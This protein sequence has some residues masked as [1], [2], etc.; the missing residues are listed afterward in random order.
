MTM[1]LATSTSGGYVREVDQNIATA[2]T[3]I[4]YDGLYRFPTPRGWSIL[5]ESTLRI[6]NSNL[7]DDVKIRAKSF[8]NSVNPILSLLAQRMNSFPQ[9]HSNLLEDGSVIFEL[10]RPGIRLTFNIES[11]DDESSWNLTTNDKKGSVWS[12][13]RLFP[14][15][16]MNISW[17]VTYLWFDEYFCE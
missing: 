17:I 12:F 15:P 13:G 10:A 14:F 4:G 11:T 8:L 16:I 1:K 5:A 6:E 3:E 7:E 9:L 2:T